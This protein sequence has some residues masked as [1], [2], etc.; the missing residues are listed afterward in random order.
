MIIFYVLGRE[1]VTNLYGNLLLSKI[2]EFENF[3]IQIS[4][5]YE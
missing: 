4:L 3:F 1:S 5:N 2:G